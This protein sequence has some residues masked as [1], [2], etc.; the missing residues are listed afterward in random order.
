[1]FDGLQAGY[2]QRS[3]DA[4]PRQGTRGARR[5]PMDYAVDH[6][7]LRGP[8]QAPALRFGTVPAERPVPA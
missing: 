4:W 8:V 5:A 2:I 6:E 3:V 1:M 7:R